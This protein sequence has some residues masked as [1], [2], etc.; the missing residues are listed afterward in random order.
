MIKVSVVGASG[1]VGQELVRLLHKHPHV[2][3]HRIT[4]R[5]HA[6]QR[7]SQV[8][9]SFCQQYEQEFEEVDLEEL[10]EESDAVFIALPH[11]VAS[12]LVTR[13]ILEKTRVI[14][15]GADFRLQDA[16]L[17]EEWYQ[18][19]HPSPQLLRESIYGLCE[20]HGDRIGDYRLVAN[21]GCFTTCSILSTAPLMAVDGVQTDSIII[22]AKTGLSGAGRNPSPI[23]HFNEANE[24]TKAY[25]VAA[26]RHTPEIEEQLA[27]IKKQNMHL[28][29]TPH[30]VPMNRG[31]LTTCYVK[32]DGRVDE[33]ELRSRYRTF[34]QDCPF[35]RI[36]NP[37]VWPE[38]RWV[39]GSNFCDIG[40]QLDS[41]TNTVVIIGAID[42]LV[43]GAAGQGVQNM[44]IL[45]DWEQTTGLED[46]P[47]FPA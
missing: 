43:K 18:M 47:V 37:G 24:S 15:M 34:Y 33:E 2:A 11:G 8:Y 6:G 32:T 27:A 7:Y 39:K 10:A 38:T 19:K 23:T 16:G 4:S 20:I 28:L 42:N 14:D 44:N 13:A 45:F 40:L 36:A 46:L 12:G 35:V 9:G 31:I 25:K 17:Y 1:Y 5:S 26:H 30:L 29:F 21:P 3:L 41:R 22:D